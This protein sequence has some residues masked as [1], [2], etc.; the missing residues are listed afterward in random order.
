ME[1]KAHPLTTVGE[2]TLAEL[3]AIAA[4]WDQ[5]VLTDLDFLMTLATHKCVLLPYHVVRLNADGRAESIVCLSYDSNSNL[6]KPR[7]LL[8]VL[9]AVAL[10][11]AKTAHVIRR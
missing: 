3:K 6:D 8:A 9:R 10:E 4:G 7:I 2:L 1:T 5:K 11:P